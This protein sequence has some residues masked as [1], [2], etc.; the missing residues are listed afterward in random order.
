MKRNG[1]FLISV[2]LLT[3]SLLSC[4]SSTDESETEFGNQNPISFAGTIETRSGENTSTATSSA[5]EDGSKMLLLATGV[6]WNSKVVSQF[7]GCTA[8][9]AA[10]GTVLNATTAQLY[11]DDFGAG[12]P[13][14]SD[15]STKGIELY[16]IAVNDGGNTDLTDMATLKTQDTWTSFPCDFSGDQSNWNAKGS[17]KDYV[18]SNNISNTEALR[19]V[20][21]SEPTAALHFT[22]PFCK[23]SVNLIKGAGYDALDVTNVMLK[24]FNT[25]GTLN[26]ETGNVTLDATSPSN[27][28]TK[29]AVETPS[30]TR[31]AY[32]YDCLVL[33][34]RD[35][36]TA[37][38][39]V[40]LTIGGN[41][42]SVN[43]SDIVNDITEK[44]RIMN[45]GVHYVF[46]I[47]VNKSNIAT[48]ATVTDWDKVTLSDTPSNGTAATF[49]TPSGEG[50]LQ[51]DY[52]L[53]LSSAASST[54]PSPNLTNFGATPSS[55]YAY[56]N[57]SFTLATG[58]ST[59][60]WPD[61]S[62]YYHFRALAPTNTTVNVDASG[63]YVQLTTADGIHDILLGAPYSDAT[64]ICNALGATSNAIQL[65][66]KHKMA[67][68]NIRLQTTNAD[69]KVNLEGAKVNITAR[70]SGHLFLGDGTN[71]CYGEINTY[72]PTFTYNSEIKQGSCTMSM[73]P[74]STTGLIITVT[75]KDGNVY[76][77][78]N[79]GVSAWEQGKIYDYTLTL[80]KTNVDINSTVSVT[81]WSRYTSSQTITIE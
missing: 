64:T 55:Q 45:G 18:I 11:W 12:D 46:N 62:T 53:Y 1:I 21:G 32:S 34:G 73:V 43:T 81:E 39:A 25:K 7:V 65:I 4:N 31:F 5:F 63:D 57:G 54:K 51:Q 56:S 2:T 23:I 66:F 42:Y 59:I 9:A 27:D 50:T 13:N 75:T 47:T 19:Y 22:H 67:E 61:N 28:I 52:D 44:Y 40:S 78:R 14:H 30:E 60:Y 33:P 76:T 69:D 37:S 58:Y 10:E 16:G 80:K 15:V 79:M 68:M 77:I 72:T 35:L 29:M 48:T 36:N 17:S 8:D 71:N 26:I 24:G 6:T 74:Q 41:I 20:K 70:P 49:Y 3:S 38:E